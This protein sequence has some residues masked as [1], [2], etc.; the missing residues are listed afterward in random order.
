ML[1]I[2]SDI[3]DQAGINLNAHVFLKTIFIF[4]VFHVELQILDRRVRIIRL[5]CPA[6]MYWY[7]LM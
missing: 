7:V 6:L 5:F 3:L 4:S 2:P 1:Q